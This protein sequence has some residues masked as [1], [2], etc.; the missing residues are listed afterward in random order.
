VVWTPDGAPI[1]IAVYF[2]QPSKHAKTRN[3]VVA[4]ATRAVVATLA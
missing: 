3:D 4:D 2:T 1:V